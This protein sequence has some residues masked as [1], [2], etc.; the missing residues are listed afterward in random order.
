[1][2]IARK[3]ESASIHSIATD[4]EP[5]PMSHKAAAPRGDRD[6][7]RGARA[8]HALARSAERFQNRQLRF[9][10]TAVSQKLRQCRRALAVAS[11]DQNARA[12]LKMRSDQVE[13]SSMQ[14]Q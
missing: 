14:R 13:R 8:A 4:P 1:M 7:V 5:D 2:A 3:D 12:G 10:K 11:E 9:A 6:R